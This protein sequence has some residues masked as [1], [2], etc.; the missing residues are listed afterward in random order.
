[1]KILVFSDAHGYRRTMKNAIEAHLANGGVDRLFF[2]GDGINCFGDVTEDYRDIPHDEVC[3]NCDSLSAAFGVETDAPAELLV[4]AGG[5]K[6][7]LAHGHRLGVK[8]GIGRAAEYAA[9]R[10]ADVLLYGHTHEKDDC[11]EYVNGK[12]IRCINPGSCSVSD[13]SFALLEIIDGNIVCG[14]GEM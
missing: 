7:L 6:F 12:A 3:G 13:K 10:G 4:S 14:F 11:I 8:S 1:M 2:L 9:S 5:K